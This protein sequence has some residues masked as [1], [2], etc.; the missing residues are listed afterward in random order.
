MRSATVSRRQRED[1]STGRGGRSA[2]RG[3]SDDQPVL[4][5]LP[6]LT[7][8]VPCRRCSPKHRTE[9]PFQGRGEGVA[10][11]SLL[12]ALDELGEEAL[13]DEPLGRLL[14]SPRERR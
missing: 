13:D 11:R 12:E 14:G 7:L 5:S 10:R 1:T 8:R 3:R 6:I 4:S 9:P 2:P